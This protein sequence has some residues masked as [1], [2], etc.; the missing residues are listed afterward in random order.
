MVIVEWTEA[1][2]LPAFFLQA[3]VLAYDVNDVVCLLNLINY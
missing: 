3:H 1:D 2:H